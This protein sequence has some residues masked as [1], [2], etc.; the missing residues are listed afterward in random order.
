[1]YFSYTKLMKET[2]A[3]C[4]SITFD[5]APRNLSMCTSLCTNCD[6]FSSSFKPW[7][8]NSATPEQ[9]NQIYLFWDAAHMLKLVCNTLGEKQVYLNGKR[10]IIRW[11]H[12]VKLQELQDSKGLHA[13]N[14]FK[15]KS[16][17]IS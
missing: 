5:G 7:F 16:Y 14:K 2:G 4:H 1:M 9:T 11:N 17:T 10:E 15:R 8:N 12:I 3:V 13:A 6:Y